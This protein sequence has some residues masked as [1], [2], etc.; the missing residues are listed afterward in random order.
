M[1]LYAFLYLFVATTTVSAILEQASGFFPW[2]G[3]LQSRLV[4]LMMK[5]I[6][7]GVFWGSYAS[8]L[9]INYWALFQSWH[10]EV[11]SLK[12]SVC[13]IKRSYSKR[14]LWSDP[15]IFQMRSAFLDVE[16]IF[17]CGLDAKFQPWASFYNKTLAH[18]KM[19]ISDRLI[20]IAMLDCTVVTCFCSKV[21]EVA[22]TVKCIFHKYQT[23]G[24]NYCKAF[25]CLKA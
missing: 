16:K 8:T 14:Q 6:F 1:G 12:G 11:V 9:P 10:I 21:S 3:C 23:F 13:W 22:P 17:Q 4:L 19:R 25:G 24:N 20:I 2:E 18:E 15:W 5:L 7:R